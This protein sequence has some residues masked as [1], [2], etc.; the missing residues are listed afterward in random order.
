MKVRCTDVQ[1]ILEMWPEVESPRKLALQLHVDDCAVCRSTNGGCLAVLRMIDKAGD[2]Y[3]DL[4]YPGPPPM[5]SPMPVPILRFAAACSAVILVTGFFLVRST[6]LPE[7][8]TRSFARPSL[9]SLARSP[10]WPSGIRRSRTSVSLHSIHLS[11]HRLESQVRPYLPSL[12]Y[13]RQIY[14]TIRQESRQGTTSLLC[15]QSETPTNR[16][17]TT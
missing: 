14:P 6:F 2:S 4:A 13:P 11:L 5:V 15:A 7:R 12:R 10:Q 3:R 16:R 8:A 9:S 17:T 1:A